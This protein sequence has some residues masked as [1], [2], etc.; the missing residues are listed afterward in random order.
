MWL[1]RYFDFES[2]YGVLK[3][4]SPRFLLNKNLKFKKSERE[5]LLEETILLN[6]FKETITTCASAH[7]RIPNQM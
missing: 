3:S 6:A 5:T 2:N 7:I 4:K 1:F